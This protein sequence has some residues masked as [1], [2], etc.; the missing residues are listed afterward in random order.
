MGTARRRNMCW[1]LLFPALAC[2]LLLLG[3][4]WI[5]WPWPT[6][7][8]CLEN[9]DTYQ[10]HWSTIKIKRCCA[11]NFVPCPVEQGDAR[12]DFSPRGMVD[13]F[14]C[15]DGFRD[16]QAEWSTLKKQWCCEHH[17]RGCGQDAEVA[18]AQY[19]CNSAFANWVK[20]WSEGKKGWCCSRGVKCCPG[21]AIAAGKGY[22]GGTVTAQHGVDVKGAPVAAFR[23]IP[24]EIA[25]R[26]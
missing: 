7:D 21:D 24:H 17:G 26:R 14:N 19:D 15:A 6:P 20:G 12:P 25:S 10:Y 5:C 11:R 18:A 8:E 4:I 13:P 9:R 23:A 1:L 16:W 22:G 2:L 3:F